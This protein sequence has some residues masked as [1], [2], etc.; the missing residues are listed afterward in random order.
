MSDAAALTDTGFVMVP[1]SLGSYKRFLRVHHEMRS[2]KTGFVLAH[3]NGRGDFSAKA[4]QKIQ[5][6]DAAQYP[7]AN[8]QTAIQISTR[9]DDAKLVAT[10]PEH[11][12]LGSDR[13]TQDGRQRLEHS[14][15]D[16]IPVQVI[17]SLKAIYVEHQHNQRELPAVGPY[18]FPAQ[19]FVKI[20]EVVDTRQ[21]IDNQSPIV[22]F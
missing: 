7:F 8:L 16:D 2:S 21:A 15:S 6:F 17:Y 22:E 13:G 9:Q 10:R 5:I 12:I 4:R 18:D 11:K 20:S 14:V 19:H 1:I 3:S